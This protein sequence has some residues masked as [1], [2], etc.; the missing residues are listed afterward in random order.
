MQ[1]DN[2]LILHKDIA[3]FFEQSLWERKA[4]ICAAKVMFVVYIDHTY[5]SIGIF[6]Q[7]I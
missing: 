2:H 4:R 6:S 3:F 1:A 7:I 5:V